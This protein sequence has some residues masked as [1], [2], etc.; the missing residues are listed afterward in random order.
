[1]SPTAA[2]IVT[3]PRLTPVTF[4]FSSTVAMDSSLEVNTGT[5]VASIG[6]FFILNW[7]LLPI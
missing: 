7:M 4:Q 3:F 6:V 5:S 1:M 2:V